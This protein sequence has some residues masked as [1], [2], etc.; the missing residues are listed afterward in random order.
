MGTA[1][2]STSTVVLIYA[3]GQGDYELVALRAGTGLEPRV[4]EFFAS[5]ALNPASRE[6][7]VLGPTGFLESACYCLDALLNDAI[8]VGLR[9]RCRGFVLGADGLTVGAREDESVGLVEI[10][11]VRG[12][13]D[14]EREGWHE[15]RG[16]MAVQSRL[17]VKA[18]TGRA[19]FRDARTARP[20]GRV[21]SRRRRRR[22]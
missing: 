7:D 1:P 12:A 15:G 19:D 3:L 6:L 9:H 18:R 22:R 21:G 2:R 5:L 17:S 13:A 4:D 8:P 20:V 14:C 11:L 16:E 10:L